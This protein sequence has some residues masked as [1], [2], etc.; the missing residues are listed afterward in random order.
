MTAPKILSFGA[1]L[2]LL[3][4]VATT[5]SEA[6]EVARPIANRVSNFLMRSREF[7]NSFEEW[8]MY[9]NQSTVFTINDSRNLGEI[10]QNFE[11]VA[12]ALKSE[13]DSVVSRIPLALSQY[14]GL[15]GESDN[16]TRSIG[17]MAAF[18]SVRNIAIS[19]IRYVLDITKSGLEV[20]PNT[21]VAKLLRVICRALPQL[22][23]L[24]H[25]APSLSFFLAHINQIKAACELL[26]MSERKK[27]P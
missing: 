22:T 17:I 15:A 12:V 3:E 10:Q 2:C 20:L 8:R 16:K 14:A 5:M 4:N 23:T 18:G 11:G 25:N 9:T 24:A 19:L 1:H 26:E 7:V 21:R 6:D 27:P 13:G